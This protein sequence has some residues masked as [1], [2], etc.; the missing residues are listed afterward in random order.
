MTAQPLRF[1]VIVASRERPLWLRRCLRAIAA[2]DY[3][4]FEV[5]VVADPAG[6]ADIATSGAKAVP[7]DEPNLA[8]AR[9]AGI[10]AAAGEVCAFIDDDA[11]PEPL[12]LVH[13]ADAFSATGADAVTGFVRGRNGISF[14]SRVASVDAEAETHVEPGD[15][16]TPFV[17]ALAPG[18]ALKLVGTNMAVRRDVLAEIGGFDEMLRFFLDDT[19]LSL[20]LARAGKR[21]AVAPLA[22]VHHAFAPSARRTA[23]RAPTDLYDIGRSTAIYLGR[24]L[25]RADAEW[26]ERL[27][28]RERARLIRH[29]IAGTCEPRDVEPRMVR[30]AEGWKEGKGRPLAEIRLPA[31]PQTD[32]TPMT[33]APPG[34]RIVSAL[35]LWRRRRMLREAEKVA[36]TGQRVTF[37]SF[38]LTPVRHHLRYTPSGVW[39][40]TGGLW[41]RSVRSGP[42]IVWCRF[43]KRARQEIRRVAKV[44]GFG[45]SVSL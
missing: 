44:R 23:L 4:A 34:H 19:D 20:R 28:T 38:S 14:Q 13:L 42:F 45:D 8:K 5:V 27:E 15:G 35:F 25:G 16:E 7:F 33:P 41:G 39:V 36:R 26:F 1:S 6:L 37:L 17:P 10:A 32:F 40:Q 2:L 3:P 22:E 11:V 21:L 30:L 43:A 24:H 31:S 9:N 12:W 29:M 18:R